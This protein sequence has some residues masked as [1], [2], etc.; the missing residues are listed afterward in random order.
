MP[1]LSFNLRKEYVDE[2]MKFIKGIDSIKLRYSVVR[3]DVEHHF[4]VEGELNGISKLV[5]YLSKYGEKNAS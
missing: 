5:E 1:E 2:T 3:N 4:F